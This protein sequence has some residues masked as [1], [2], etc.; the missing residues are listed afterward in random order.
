[1][2]PGIFIVEDESIVSLEIQERIKSLGYLLAGTASSGEEALESLAHCSADLVI[3]DIKLRGALDGIETAGLIKQKF[4]LPVIFLTAYADE[5]TLQRAKITEPYAYI[6]KPF[7]ER[8]LHT[9]IEIAIYKHKTEKQIKEKDQWLSVIL[10]SIGDGVIATDKEKKIVFMNDVAER[11]TRFRTNESI[12]KNLDDIFKLLNGFTGEALP[13]PVGDVL[14]FCKLVALDDYATLVSRYGSLRP[15]MG[16]AAPIKGENN[17]ALGIVL[18]FQDMSER[19]KA[20]AAVKESEKKFKA[21][22]ENSPGI[23][24]LFSTKRGGLYFSPRAYDILYYS[25]REL[26]DDPNLYFNSVDKE[27]R[28][29]IFSLMHSVGENEVIS[30]EHRITD[31]RKNKK[32]LETKAICIE[33]IGDELI[34]QCVANDIT[35]R[36]ISGEKISLQA[37]ALDSA[38]NGILIADAEGKIVYC[39]KSQAEMSGY[40]VEEMIGKNPRIFKSGKQSKE[41]YTV[42]WS[43]IKSGRGWHGE[44]V[45]RRKDKSL[46]YEDLTIT[47]VKDLNGRITHFVAIKQDISERKKIEKELLSAKV[48]AEKSSKMKTE[49]IAQMSHEIRTPVNN[50]V[51]YSSLI[52][53]ELRNAID[54]DLQTGFDAIDRGCK[55]LIRTI[56]L[57]LNMA[58]VQSGSYEAKPK[59]LNIYEDII[60]NVVHEFR[61]TAEAKGL[62]FRVEDLLGGNYYVM[63]DEYSVTQVFLNLIDNAFKFTDMGN[64]VIRMEHD[65]L[66]SK[67]LVKVIDS[68][69]G[70]AEEY[71][72]NLFD[73]FSQEDFG[74]TRGYEGNGLG[75][76]LVK[77]YCEINNAVIEVESGKGK[78]TTFTVI[79]HA[80]K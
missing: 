33:K 69:I 43:T 80:A 15:I 51:S 73:P 50:I 38:Y 20:E 36:K 9:N 26:L 72:P 59:P 24:F 22:V 79:F 62:G 40:T 49:F 53:G 48:E 56:D 63:A 67:T 76:S 13:D 60:I 55:R 12:G 5:N 1:M 27:D 37:S 75:L 41:Y 46:Y 34:F 45:N 52:S 44:L 65:E 2:T 7:E 54:E 68:G 25:I 21:I 32:W 10:R 78:G 8:E 47:P 17:T 19:V 66:N 6:I 3:M 57:L 11:L 39:N 61:K 31:A 28:E 14:K 23:V 35:E 4:D 18:V 70:I 29:R 77:K 74:F 64:V 30:F 71:L 58:S 42:L 16:T